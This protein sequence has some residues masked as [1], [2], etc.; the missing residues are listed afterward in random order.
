MADNRMVLKFG[1][2]LVE[3]LGAQLYPSATATVA[4]LISNAWDADARHV[5]VEIPFGDSWTPDSEI[6]VTDDGH[7][8]SGVEAQ[9]T[10]LVVGRK[11]R[12][13]PTGDRSLGGRLVHGRKGIGKLAAFGTAGILECTTLSVGKSAVE[14]R[15]DYDEIRK[16]DPNEDYEVEE[17]EFHSVLSD[18]AGS[19]LTHGTRIRLTKL[20]LKRA[21]SEEQFI[22]S[23]SR[24]FAI[25][26]GEMEVF[27]NGTAL[28]RFDT[29]LQ[30]RFPNVDQ[31]P[32]ETTLDE[33]GW[34]IDHVGDKDVR[35][36]IGFSEKPIEDDTML[37]ISI[38]ARGKM[39]QRP[40]RFEHSQGTEGQ[41][42][43]EYMV[44]EVEA[45][46]LDEGIDIETDLIQSNRDQLQLEDS[47]LSPLLEWG[48]KKLRWA[49]RERNQ[50][51]LN[52]N[53]KE[54]ETAEIQQLLVNSTRAEKAQILKIAAAVA[55]LPEIEPEDV[56][57]IVQGVMDAREDVMVRSLMEE[58]NAEDEPFQERMWQ[59]VHEFGLIDARRNLSL[60]EARIMTIEKL[61]TA[62]SNGSREVPDLHNIIRDNAWLIDPRWQLLDDE[63]DISTFG[64]T[65]VP[66]ED[67]DG[68][69]LDFLF[70]L[71]PSPPANM[72]E[73]VVIEIKRGTNKDKSLHRAN[74]DEIDKFSTYVLAVHDYLGRN[75]SPPI[76]RGLLVASG[77]TQAADR[78]RR[79][80][81][82]SL[83]PRMEFKT[84]DA[85]IHGTKNMHE[86]WLAVST[87]RAEEVDVEEG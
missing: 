83:D 41:L 39:A 49:L 47:R 86:G 57:D 58:I 64:V 5:W 6:F 55:K 75:S 34:G 18:P 53:V 62:V 42:G 52:E 71:R 23:M 48:R 59:L 77:Y 31:C 3:Q 69:Q 63:V 51:R 14:F 2:S 81:S 76:V 30:F 84:W 21:S 9:A 78:K 43:L 27:I 74:D 13:G 10:Y 44:G 73:V 20:L 16:L 70:V 8:M 4:E 66:E 12:L 40:F 56:R 85:V 25:S 37:G 67:E 61:E 60:I 54:F 65:Y 19:K 1:G 35:W 45:D 17:V 11:R 26:Q 15:L 7:G 38:L 29:P 46:W 80:L 87:K 79:L 72:D 22:Q 28:K 36:W 33:A 82:Q 68:N 24:R 32:E 50:L